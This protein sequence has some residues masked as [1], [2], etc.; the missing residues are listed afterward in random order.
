MR[1]TRSW[2]SSPPR[3]PQRPPQPSFM[4]VVLP[5]PRAQA[6]FTP[7][8]PLPCG[9]HFP[10]TRRWAPSSRQPRLQPAPSKQV[11][12]LA[13]PPRRLAAPSFSAMVCCTFE[14]LAVTGCVFQTQEGPGAPSTGAAGASFHS[15][16]RALRARQDP[17][18]GSPF[19][20]VARPVL[21]GGG[22]HQDLPDLPTRQSRLPS[23]GRPPLSPACA[24]TPQGFASARGLDFIELFTARSGHDF[25]QVHIDLL[26]GRVWLAPTTKTATT[27]TV[28]RNFFASVFS[29]VRLPDVL[30]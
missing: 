10:P 11:V 9:R 2:N 28:A 8:S 1:W 16:G 4:S 12:P 27:V 15:L 13:A 25:V 20:V 21:R 22:V 5:P 7:T 19:R 24:D 3:L 14:V 26:T 18:A 29:D 6:F 23:A 17:R 30:V